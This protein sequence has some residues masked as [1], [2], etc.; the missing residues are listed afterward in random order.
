MFLE[1]VPWVLLN[2]DIFL[3]AYGG[4]SVRVSLDVENAAERVM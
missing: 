4:W 2:R 3:R 1:R